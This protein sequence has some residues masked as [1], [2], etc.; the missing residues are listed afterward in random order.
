MGD[1]FSIEPYGC[2]RKL[3]YIKRGVEPDYPLAFDLN[4]NVQRGNALESIIRQMFEE[5]HGVKV[6]IPE[7]RRSGKHPFLLATSDGIYEKDRKKRVLEL[8]AP[9]SHAYIKHE[10]TGL[11]YSYILQLQEYLYVWDLEI[12]T[13]CFLSCD[14]WKIIDFDVKRDDELVAQIIEKAEH[15]WKLIENGPI[16]E[17][18][19][20]GDKRCKGC[21]WK[22]ECWGALLDESEGGA[23]SDYELW[24]D[25]EFVKRC[26]EFD[27]ARELVKQAKEVLKTSTDELKEVLGEREK[28]RCEVGKVSYQWVPKKLV[29][30]KRLKADHPDIVKKYQYDS[31]SHK[32]NLYTP[33]KKG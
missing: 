13:F 33:K 21:H 24:E 4:P 5:K 19:A 16:P 30:N 11:P 7:Q 32:L 17:R 15:F 22:M 23:E 26:R 27:E 29:D 3:F 31:T 20:D 12:G 1:L 25:E 28:V 6:E 8:K 2:E 10:K 9:G 14:K 18:L